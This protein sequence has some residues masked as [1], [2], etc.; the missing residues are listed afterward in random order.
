MAKT[1]DPLYNKIRSFG[2]Q[3][4]SALWGY[5]QHS[6][7]GNGKKPDVPEKFIVVFEDLPCHIN[8]LP[9]RVPVTIV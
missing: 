3:K 5:L 8:F 9:S 4:A 2:S 1:D 7:D 6:Q